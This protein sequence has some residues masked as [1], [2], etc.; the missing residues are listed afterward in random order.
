MPDDFAPPIPPAVAAHFPTDP[1]EAWLVVQA[2]AGHDRNWLR[3]NRA[4]LHKVWQGDPNGI[5]PPPEPSEPGAPPDR[6][7]EL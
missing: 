3:R 6:Y 4:A 5:L 7:S 1:F 2:N